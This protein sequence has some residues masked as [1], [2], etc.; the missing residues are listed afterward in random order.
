MKSETYEMIKTLHKFIGN[1]LYFVIFL[2]LLYLLF[3]YLGQGQGGFIYNEFFRKGDS[4][5][6][7]WTNHYWYDRDNWTAAQLQ[8]DYPVY[9][10]LGEHIWR[11]I[12]A[13]SDSLAAH[14]D[15]MGL[16][17]KSPGGLWWRS[18]KC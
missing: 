1:D 17:E 2:A 6:R 18:M 13:D 16:P 4:C 11:P 3:S 9:D 12:V 14:I 15:Q 8:P 5:S 10:V 7:K